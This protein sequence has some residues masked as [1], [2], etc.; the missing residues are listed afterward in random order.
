[1]PRTLPAALTTVMDTGI[2]E[3]Y[4]R[5]VINAEPNDSG[6][7]TL[8]PMAYQLQALKATV[9]IPFNAT[10]STFFRL[11]RGAVINGTP[12]TISS[13]WFRTIEYKF[14]G[15]FIILE[16]EALERSYLSVAADS[17]YET[18]ITTALVDTFNSITPS[19]EGAAAW[20]A[21][22]FY[23]A[24]KAIVL[25]PRK[26]LFTMLKQKYLV[27]AT[28][29]GWDGSANN[30]FF[31]LATATRSVDY[32][33][34]DLLFNETNHVET[35]K[36]LTRDEVNSIH[37]NG[38]ATS[39]IHN[40]GFL[41]STA[42]LPPN[43]ENN[44]GAKSSRLPV[45]LKYRTGDFVTFQ[46]HGNGTSATHRINVIEVLDLQATPAW[47]QVLEALEW[48]G[49]TEGGAMPSTIEAAAPY[50]PLAT[51]NFDKVL[52][53]NDNN[54]QAAMETLDE[55]DHAGGAAFAEVVQDIVGAM[56]SSNTET[57][58]VVTYQDSDG[59]IDFET[60]AL[61]ETNTNDIFFCSTPG[62]T[63]AFVGT[64][65]GAPSG[66]N[67]TYNVTSGT[68]GAMTV[69]SSSQI[70]KMRLYNTTRG[71]SALISSCNTGTNVI[72][73]TAN[74]PANWANGDTITIASQTVSGGGFSWVDV[75]ITSG[76]TSKNNL[77]LNLIF[78][79]AT[80]G[81][82]M[83]LHPFDASHSSSKYIAAVALAAANTNVFGLYKC[84]SNVISLSWT[85]TPSSV[86]IRE[87]GY[88][89]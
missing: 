61:A 81:D 38:A 49:G 32:T 17:D 78:S 18:V 66:A 8:Q 14:D 36:L 67:V 27:F 55:H 13:I 51:G 24:G 12:S 77:F 70:G 5:V 29:D 42:S 57:G 79:S 83:R 19:F 6:A 11:V 31:F 54:I 47:Y 82:T 20:K 76:P 15:K 33:V 26:N 34:T 63:S 52:S 7:A 69:S 56:V 40:L 62:G 45:H 75:E 88:L 2:Y 58:I 44:V 50:T 71:N 23:P 86:A 48:F 84:N 80:V 87:A 53:V 41:H 1:M 9:K 35:R 39:I 4:I 37:T 65:N 68:E 60:T 89:Y 3:P 21:Y 74:A 30:M 16:G 46:K 25:S 73:L 43:V 22:T 10:E 28:E 59:T 85:G 64:I 72:T